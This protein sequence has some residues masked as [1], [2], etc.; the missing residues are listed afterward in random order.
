MGVETVRIIAS[1]MSVVGSA[2]LAYRVTGILQALGIVAIAHEENIN[3]LMSPGG[4][5]IMHFTNSTAHV[6]RAKKSG[7][8][9]AGFVLVVG[10]ATLQFVALLMVN[11]VG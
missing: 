9:I 5:D 11:G 7:L 6:K 1:L 4:G 10:A 3:Q 2:I 8:L